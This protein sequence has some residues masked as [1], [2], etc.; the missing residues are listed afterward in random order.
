MKAAAQVVLCVCT[1][2]VLVTPL[3]CQ[4]PKTEATAPETA[5]IA[6][7]TTPAAPSSIASKRLIVHLEGDKLEVDAS[8]ATLKEVLDKITAATNITITGNV[9]VDVVFGHFG[10]CDVSDLIIQMI[11]G[12]GVNMLLIDH[13]GQGLG[14]E[15]I[16]SERHGGPDLPKPSTNPLLQPQDSRPSEP[17]DKP[18]PSEDEGEQRMRPPQPEV[19]G[20]AK[21]PSASQGTL[22]HPQ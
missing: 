14:G 11:A 4:L 9:P 17:Q 18:P 2:V 16:L 8:N 13:K 10:P 21:A 1:F 3:W 7:S 5:G 19:G 22:P 12:T 20:P 15:L 6:P